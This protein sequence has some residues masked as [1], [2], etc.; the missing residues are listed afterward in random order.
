MTNP[1]DTII[2]LPHILAVLALS[3]AGFLLTLLIRGIKGEGWGDGAINGLEAALTIL[4]GSVLAQLATA[5][6][7][8]LGGGTTGALTATGF[9][10][11]IWPGIIN[12]IGWPITGGA[13]IGADGLTWFA[14]AV[15]AG[16]GFF[17]GFRKVHKW[18]GP[19]VLTFTADM[20]W[21]LPLTVN[22]LL[23][24]LINLF[25]GE[26]KP[27]GRTG[28]TRY[29]SGFRTYG[30]FAFTQGNVL[31]NLSEGPGQPLNNHEQTHV[32]QNRIFGPLFWTTYFGWL[33]LFGLFGL[34]G[35]AVGWG[36]NSAGVKISNSFPMW[37]G[38]FNNPWE[39]WAYSHNPG[40]RTSNLPRGDGLGWVD[41]PGVLKVIFSI[42][43][44]AILIGLDLLV[45]WATWF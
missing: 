26:A 3:L 2:S 13:V 31:S 5:F 19:G 6:L 45:V 17:D 18:A 8:W 30:D 36:K 39:L 29:E 22:A 34:I 15:G 16:A 42:I 44:L 25:W 35:M 32:L 21:G 40:G 43:G 37:W 38:Y 9:F 4:A 20:V 11:L 7:I 28:A 1:F 41:W 10:L 33:I 12:L 23:I 24:H 27:D 14:L